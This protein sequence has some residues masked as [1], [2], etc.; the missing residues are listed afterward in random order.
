MFV[1]SLISNFDIRINLHFIL[2]SVL[3]EKGVSNKEEHRIISDKLDEE[4]FNDHPKQRAAFHCGYHAVVGVAKYLHGNIEGG[5]AEIFRSS[6]QYHNI[7]DG[8]PSPR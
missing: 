4:Y 2:M 6:Q 8:P 7:T 5:N 3:D 1:T